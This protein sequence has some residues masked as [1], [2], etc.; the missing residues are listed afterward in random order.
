M[1]PEGCFLRLRSAC[2]CQKQSNHIARPKAHLLSRFAHDVSLS[3]S[4]QLLQWVRV[5][6]RQ[7]RALSSIYGPT[8]LLER[9]L[10]ET[11]VF[12]FSFGCSSSSPP[13]RVPCKTH[14]ING[15]LLYVPYFGFFPIGFPVFKK[16]V[17]CSVLGSTLGSYQCKYQEYQPEPANVWA[18][19]WRSAC[20][21][22]CRFRPPLFL[23][24]FLSSSTMK[25][26]YL[27]WG[28]QNPICELPELESWGLLK[29]LRVPHICHG[30]KIHL[31]GVGDYHQLGCFGRPW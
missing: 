15:D 22:F 18:G 1:L 5:W 10:Y 16:K 19:I 26:L 7:Y 27:F 2:L 25:A 28:V 30:R 29:G 17:R 12:G 6:L 3:T 13:R 21:A 9:Q 24:R 23:G 4:K 31:A 14:C 8:G 20:R 11:Q